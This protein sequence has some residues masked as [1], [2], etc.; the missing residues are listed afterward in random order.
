MTESISPEVVKLKLKILADAAKYDAS[1]ASSG[2]QRKREAGGVG[3]TEG[4]GICHSY[5]PDGRCI[6]LLKI[7]LTNFC[8]YDCK[9][10]INR[11]SS[12]TKRAKFTPEEVVWLTLQF[13]RR[14]YIEGLFLSSGIFESI[15]TTMEHLIRVA[16]LLRVEHKFGGY[17]HLKVVPGASE[18][19]IAEAGRWADRVSANIE[20]PSQ[21]DLDSLAPA[22]K[23]DVAFGA[24][25]EMKDHIQKAKDE[26][27]LRF[28]PKF[29]PAGQST[30]MIVGATPSS[31]RLILSQS[32]KLYHDFSMRRVYY[33]AYSP[34]PNADAVL[35]VQTPALVRENRLYQADWLLRFY[36]FESSEL[37]TEAEPNLDLEF[38]PKSAWAIQHREFFPVD[39]NLA[40]RERLLRVPGFGVRN[41][42]RILQLRRYKKVTRLDLLKLKV[43]WKRARF[44]V[45]TSDHNPNVYLLDR[46]H[47]SDLVK[48]RNPQLSLFETQVSAKTGEV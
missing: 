9:F 15:D 35:P 18:E 16:K 40:E 43:P 5:T 14:N 38:D 26:R 12:D 39:V 28:A 2:S 29:A 25:T 27:H 33:S 48:D 23:L 13:Y 22:K 24:M 17:I 6:S 10:C 8:L 34:I 41:V 20:L 36:G 4:M 1:C 37:L 11:V 44:F 30:Q 42:E 45:T 31:D 7:L 46:S 21:S 32:E 19:L 3:N 47:L